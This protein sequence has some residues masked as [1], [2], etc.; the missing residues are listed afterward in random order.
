MRRYSL[1][2]LVLF[3]ILWGSVVIFAQ[4][5]PAGT[6]STTPY[7][8]QLNTPALASIPTIEHSDHLVQL[9]IEH[10]RLFSNI[11]RLSGRDITPLH[12]YHHALN[13]IAIE[14]THEEANQIAQL[15]Q[16]RRL[17]PSSI[18]QPLTDVGPEWIGAPAIWD[19]T[20][21]GSAPGNM[22][23]GII[24]GVIDTGINMDHPS[25]ADIGGDG[26]DH[27]NPFGAGNYVGA[28]ATDPATFTCNDK[29]IGAWS[30][31][32]VGNSPEDEWWHGSHVAGTAAG[33]VITATMSYSTTT[34]APVISGVAPHANI[35]AYD[36]CLAGL[37]CPLTA[38]LAAIDQAI[39]DGVDIINYSLGEVARNPWEDVEAQALLAAREAGIF[40]AVAAGND[41]PSSDTILTP[42]NAPWVTTIGNST[43][44][45]RRINDVIDMSGG[46]TTPPLDLIGAGYAAGHGPA[47]IVEAQGYTNTMGMT[48]NGQC[49]ESFPAGTWNGEIVF[50]ERWG[51]NS[52]LQG[53]N[54]RDG[55]A[56]GMVV[57]TGSTAAW[58]EYNLPATSILSN[59]GAD[60]E[61][62]LNSGTGHM[63]TITGY[64]LDI[65]NAY[66][67]NMVEGS[68]RG[69]TPFALD[70]L[71]PDITAPGYRVL[72]AF[73]TD[74]PSEPPEFAFAIGTSMSSPHVAGAA[75]LLK[76]IHPT[77]TPSEIQSALQT[78]ALTDGLLKEDELTPATPHDRGSGRVDLTRSALAGLILDE[79]PANFRAADP[80]RGG[81]PAQLNL[82]S[83]SDATCVETCQ[84]TRT[85]RNPL[86]TATMWTATISQPVSLTLTVEPTSFTLL[87]GET[88]VFT[89]TADVTGASLDSWI[90]GEISF[91]EASSLAPDAYF[92]LAVQATQADLPTLIN[93]D[94]RRDEGSW[95]L[96]DLAATDVTSLSANSYGLAPA[97][98]VNQLASVDPTLTDPYDNLNDGTTFFSLVTVPA[99]SQRLVAEILS[100]T[101]PD[102]DMYVGLDTGDG[103]PEA[104][105]EVCVSAVPS[106]NED[107]DLLNPAG[108]TYWILVQPYLGSL[109]QPNTIVLS[110]GIV[111]GN[112]SNLSVSGPLGSP[113]N[114]SFALRLNWDE[115]MAV[116]TRWYGALEVG[117][118]PATP[119]DLG[120]VPINAVRMPDDVTKTVSPTAIMLD[121]TLTFTMMVQPNLLPESVTYWLTD[122]LPAGVT[123]IPGTATNGATLTGNQ[124]YWTRLIPRYGSTEL[125]TV[126]AEPN[127]QWCG[128]MANDLW[129]S[130]SNPNSQ[131]GQAVATFDLLCNLLRFPIIHRP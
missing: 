8:I 24:I 31:P 6:P 96:A 29:L 77:W 49:M 88:Q 38:M 47:L 39:A 58:R 72:A 105:E 108:G 54:V 14:L 5:T 3:L 111:S 18:R 78:T 85:V 70:V 40:V 4:P 30:W 57:E 2:L 50:C 36:V 119:D 35:I 74:D 20:A 21:T 79:N 60:L 81:Q 114:G 127:G 1:F 11:S 7:I 89:V 125:V 23:E 68:S 48:D 12:T 61:T 56:G 45:R 28:C 46:D 69:P 10:E 117:S 129:H 120:I 76:V 65:D 34:V 98:V 13:G 41:G 16:V 91:S 97:T 55:G 27:I 73:R 52:I 94:L 71:K 106:W 109:S 104:S 75:A 25:F 121:E 130:L 9:K 17:Q 118:S 37:G 62:W 51:N 110:T 92:P 86:S 128:L 95:L 26:Y 22:G 100:S 53:H 64:Q 33:N 66:G 107:C 113:I 115:T 90:F 131:T 87:P 124:L 103:L 112:E 19:G 59:A 44:N 102:V 122:T 32:E 43:H 63:A 101:A 67:D 126:Q 82:A 83:F 116:G 123:F 42:S 80:S 93:M 15:P 84:W 99:G